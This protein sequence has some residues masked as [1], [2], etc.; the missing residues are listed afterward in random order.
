MELTKEILDE[1]GVIVGASIKSLLK[2]QIIEK[3]QYEFPETEEIVDIKFDDSEEG[4]P[5]W[6]IKTD[7]LDSVDEINEKKVEDDDR[8]YLIRD[9]EMVEVSSKNE[10]LPSLFAKEEYTADNDMFDFDFVS[11]PKKMVES[12]GS[13]F[14]YVNR[15]KEEIDELFDINE[16]TLNIDGLEFPIMEMEG[17]LKGLSLNKIKN[18]GTNTD[19]P[20]AQINSQ[21]VSYGISS[22]PL[23]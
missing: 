15:N 6:M 2:K 14:N 5:V 9:L 22:T 21:S 8:W 19:V 18:E 12:L 20:Q 16:V 1:S 3:Y 17:L 23:V 4:D 13:L 10:Q 7:F 11:V